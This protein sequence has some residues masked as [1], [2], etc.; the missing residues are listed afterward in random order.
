[1]NEDPV[2]FEKIQ[3]TR[4]LSKNQVWLYYR[5]TQLLSKNPVVVR[6]PKVLFEYPAIVGKS[7]SENPFVVPKPG[8]CTKSQ[9]VV[10]KPGCCR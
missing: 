1:M 9:F 7:L 2:D 3:V 6:N 5:K 4:L 8:C 10:Q